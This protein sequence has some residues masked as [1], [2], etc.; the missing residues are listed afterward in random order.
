MR[1]SGI[2][3]SATLLS[4][5]CAD[6]TLAA[7]SP[8]DGGPYMAPIPP[9]RLALVISN[10]SY[11]DAPL[12]AAPVDAKQIQ[13]ALT[14]A[15]FDVT[16]TEDVS[17]QSDLVAKVLIPFLNRVKPGDIVAIYYFGHGFS[18]GVDN[19]LM[20][21]GASTSIPEADIYDSF[22]PERAVRQLAAERQPGIVFLF[23]D[24]CR[25][26]IQ[27]AA[28][29]APPPLVAQAPPSENAQSDF[30]ISYAADYGD[31]AFAPTESDISY[32]TNALTQKLPTPGLEFSE[33]HRQLTTTVSSTS[34]YKQKAWLYSDL[35]SLFYF[36]PTAAIQEGERQLWEATLQEG[37]R[38]AVDNFLHGNRGSIYAGEAV[39]WLV[40][41]PAG[42]AGA[43][44]T[45]TQVSPLS[46]EAKWNGSSANSVTLPKVSD[47]LGVPRS[48]TLRPEQDIKAFATASRTDLL[49]AAS[50]AIVTADAVSVS[51]PNNVIFKLPFG[52]S[53]KLSAPLGQRVTTTHIGGVESAIT[54]PPE[55]TSAGSINVGRPLSEVTLEASS[56]IPEIIATDE[57][58]QKLAPAI[59]TAQIVGWV[60]ISTP[61]DK[62]K[63]K[64]LLWTLQSTFVRYQL[65]RLGV[66]ESKITVLR[67][68]TSN[69][70]GLRVRIFGVPKGS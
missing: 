40:D 50:S 1:R 35:E 36:M 3:A 41:H 62:D 46:P 19:F 8:P 51:G 23:L 52:Q 24:A 43:R 27:F 65:T 5:L 2:V 58:K 33:L 54:L 64:Q 48:F 66:A 49:S 37:T 55:A 44:L 13:T 10:A 14:Q 26:V 34:G 59:S 53:I 6:S 69:T 63:Q 56:G 31:S 42:Q 60:S 4:L 30:A 18:H 29:G 7:P 70:G 20:P 57:I 22:L 9:H 28:A 47:T 67:N 45:Y 11:P 16:T 68:D 61:F 38:E 21:T 39:K 15:Q 12:A 17:T 25:V 32:Y